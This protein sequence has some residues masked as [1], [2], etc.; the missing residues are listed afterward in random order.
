M[1]NLGPK[2][3]II[4]FSNNIKFNIF[5]LDKACT[6]QRFSIL[7]S[8]DSLLIQCCN[9]IIVLDNGDILPHWFYLL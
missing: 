3:Y 1:N 7:K 8:P 2:S 6:P 5:R 4:S 9:I